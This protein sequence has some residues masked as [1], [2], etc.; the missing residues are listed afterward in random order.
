VPKGRRTFCDVDDWA[1]RYS[2]TP[3]R[4][5]VFRRDHGVCARCGI[6]TTA[7]GRVLKAEWHRIKQ[8]RSE[9]ERRERAEFRHR[10]RWFFR[11][12]SWDA[13]HIVPVAEGGGECTM[14]NIR[15]LC[16]PC[17]QHVT[18]EQA[19]NRASHRRQERLGHQD[20]WR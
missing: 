6:D 18:K 9:Q 13:D 16:V 10:Y 15:T 20:G 1:T 11:C 14:A 7:L 5:R 12:T 3:M 8:A 19:R 17:H 2:P 4:Q